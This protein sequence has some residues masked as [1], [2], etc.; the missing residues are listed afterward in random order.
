M[1]EDSIRNVNISQPETIH[2]LE[3]ATDKPMK[4][5]KRKKGYNPKRE[6]DSVEIQTKTQL[7]TEPA[8]IEDGEEENINVSDEVSINI[9][10][11]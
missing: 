3:H 7:E 2:K 8:D 9:L 4:R 10:V 6:K 1:S 11:K 5:E